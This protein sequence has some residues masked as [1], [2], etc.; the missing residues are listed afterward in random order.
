VLRQAPTGWRFV[1]AAESLEITFRHTSGENKQMRYYPETLGSGVAMFDYDGDGWMDLYFVT[2]NFLAPDD[3]RR[4]SNP[5]N[6]L[7]RNLGGSRF[8]D[9]TAASGLADPG[10]G[11]G[12]T[13]GDFDND[14]DPDVYVTNFGL[15]AL[16]RNNG[17]GTFSDVTGAAGVADAGM[18]TSAAWFDYDEDGDLDLYVCNY[19]VYDV[20]HPYDCKQPGV[21][22]IYCGPDSM[23]SQRDT[24][25]RNNGDGTFTDVTVEMGIARDE[26][27]ERLGKGLGVIA[28]DLN[29]DGH[30]DLAV[31][32]DL[33]PNFLFAGDGRRLVDHSEASG[34]TTNSE[35]HWESCMGIDAGDIDGDGDFDLFVTNQ[36]M[37]KNSLYRNEGN[38]LFQDVS[39]FCGLGYAT[40]RAVGWGTSL[41]DFD[42]DGD[43]DHFVTNGHFYDWRGDD[44][45]FRQRAM[46]FE[47]TGAGRFQDV[48]RVAGPYFDKLLVG[49]GA[50]FGDLDNDGDADIVISHWDD[51]CEVLRNDSQPAGAWLRLEL[52]GVT[53]NRDAVGATI[54]V[55]AAGRQ[56]VYQRKAGGSYLSSNDPRVLIGLGRAEVVERLRIR[57]PSGAVQEFENVKTR[58]SYRL[59]EGT[60]PEE[61]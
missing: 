45:P 3:T 55:D 58:R 5:H 56:L 14:G 16:Y 10:F 42:N 59:V 9:V 49:R 35:G 40:K 30:V 12:A 15:N 13:V 7:Y 26:S 38:L 41:V 28:A 36:W 47:N 8:V 21:G 48:S 2:S 33:T 25:Y 50:A 61:Q 27:S 34:I 4:S 32:N 23:V 46:L 6:V 20:A 52:I 19:A 51:R 1:E 24:L 57:W 54:E 39:E 60:S 29:G 44:Q 18:S 31:A 37:E 43:L 17:D 11:H 53:C 22:R